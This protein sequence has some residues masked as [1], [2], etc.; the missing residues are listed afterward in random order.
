MFEFCSVNLQINEHDDDDDDD[1]DDDN[2][3]K[4]HELSKFHTRV[5]VI[6]HGT[7]IRI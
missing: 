4:L 1:D 2:D 7:D 5:F 3:G 6:T